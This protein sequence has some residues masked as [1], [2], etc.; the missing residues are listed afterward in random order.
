MQDKTIAYKMRITCIFYYANRYLK[1]IFFF[2]YFLRVIFLNQKIC[3]PGADVLCGRPPRAT[4][5]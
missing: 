4:Q 3:R 2:C 1:S 5:P